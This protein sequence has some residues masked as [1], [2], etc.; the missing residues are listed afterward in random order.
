MMERVLEPEVMDTA[1][2]ADGYDS[3]DFSEPN[4]AFVGRLVELGARG[5]MLDIGT[6]PGHIPLL[7]CERIVDARVVGI[8]LARHMLAHAERHRK[9]SPHATRVEFRI[10]DAKGLEFP[11]ASFDAVFSN[12]IL[13]HIPDPRPFLAE[14]RRV[15]RPGGALL[16]RDLYRPPTPERALE[17]VAL[18]AAGGSPVQRELFHAS[19]KAALTP[20]ELRAVANGAGLGEAEIVIDTDRHMSLQIPARRAGG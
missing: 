19:L 15:L 9:A 3:M 18:H 5:R 13:H 20:E 12:T 6:G 8:D 10:A 16:V 11:D 4:G 14:A 1:E 7:V 17:L 2:E